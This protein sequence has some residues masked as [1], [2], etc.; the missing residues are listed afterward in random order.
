MEYVERHSYSS[1]IISSPISVY[2]QD[3]DDIRTKTQ[4]LL[5]ILSNNYDV[6]VLVETWLA[7]NW[8]KTTEFVDSRYGVFRRDGDHTLTGKMEGGG[9]LVAVPKELAASRLNYWE[10]QTDLH[11]Y[12]GKV[13]QSHNLCS[14]YT[15]YLAS[16]LL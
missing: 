16:N 13:P 9:V 6:M 5:N 3:C 11:V 4:A 15:S 2:Y 14:L 7:A 12:P 10:N 8:C 1:K